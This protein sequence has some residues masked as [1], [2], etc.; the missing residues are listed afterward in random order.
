MLLYLVESI[1]TVFLSIV[2]VLLLAPS[3]EYPRRGNYDKRSKL[4]KSFLL[5]SSGFIL[6]CVIF[7]SA[8]VFL[9]LKI[10]F[11]F[12]EI[13]FP[14]ALIVGIQLAEFSSNLFLLRPLSLKRSE[15]LL[16]E[17]LGGIVVIFLSIFMGFFLAMYADRWFV[18]PFLVF[19]AIIVIGSPIQYFWKGNDGTDAL[20]VDAGRT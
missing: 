1:V 5:I 16:S 7:F 15:F 14:L 10:R 8:F 9:V 12:S 3:S 6:A 13:A 20:M 18:L 17:S 11:D 19:N 4:I 2:C